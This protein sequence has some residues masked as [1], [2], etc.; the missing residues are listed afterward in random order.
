MQNDPMSVDTDHNA[1]VTSNLM[2]QATPSSIEAMAHAKSSSNSV[3]GIQVNCTLQTQANQ[4][5]VP[6]RTKDLM[7]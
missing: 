1:N 6:I 2:F 7:T 3:A 5:K 4:S